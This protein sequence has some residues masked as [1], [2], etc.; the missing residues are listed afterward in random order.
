MPDE[1]AAMEKP[2]AEFQGV[3]HDADCG[4]A[5]TR[6]KGEVT[7]DDLKRNW[8]H[9]VAL[10]AEKVLGLK[11]SEFVRSVAASLS[12]APLTYSRRRD[13]LWSVVFC[14]AKRED[15]DAFCDC[16]DTANLDLS[17]DCST[18][19]RSEKDADLYRRRPANHPQRR[20]GA[21]GKGAMVRYQS[22]VERMRQSVGSL[23]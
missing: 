22:C 10:P 17:I 6:R 2:A 7:R 19:A 5:M 12:T 20:E 13:D 9:H 8:P 4:E 3:G 1:A 11:S 23:R 16:R 18:R 21:T 15:A 14:F